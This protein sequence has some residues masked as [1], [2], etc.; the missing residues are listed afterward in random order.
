M[1]WP[2]LRSALDFLGQSHHDGITIT[3]SGG[4]P[5]LE[6]PLIQRSFTHL[7]GE[8]FAGKN[9]AYRV[10]TNGTKLTE[11][12]MDF[13]VRNRFEIRISF[14]GVPNS[15]EL[16]G[17]NSF[18]ILDSR[19]DALR[20]LNETYYRRNLTMAVTI[21]PETVKYLADS[22]AYFL[23]KGVQNLTITPCLTHHGAWCD[24]LLEDL[25]IQFVRIFDMSRAHL[26]ATGEIP[27]TLFRR[28][29][30]RKSLPQGQWAMCRALQGEAVAVDM[31]GH[32]YGCGSFSPAVHKFESALMQKRADALLLGNLWD[33]D[34]AERLS[35]D[36]LTGLAVD[37]FQH[38]ER[39]YSSYRRCCDCEF[40]SDCCVCPLSI[41][42]IAGNE[43]PRRVPDF[44][45]AFNTV[46]LKKRDEFPVVDRQWQMLHNPDVLFAKIRPWLAWAESLGG[47][48]SYRQADTDF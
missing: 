3:F 48:T 7:Q 20:T 22:F 4:E 41:G 14:D 18:A 24:E 34:L 2:T 44:I 28:E 5:L 23:D 36:H 26:Q 33:G 1:P 38:K 19:L 17:K 37:I 12:R 11:E 8:E 30:N 31:E 25:E 9:F 43:D 16:R 15:Q 29:S 27:L 10:A 42:Y 40:F 35:G 13:L 21:L 46:A 32:I 47:N 39:K 45:C 6:Y